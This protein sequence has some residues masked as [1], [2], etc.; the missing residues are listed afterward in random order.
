MLKV[1]NVG[2]M[3]ELLQ[4]SELTGRFYVPDLYLLG[5]HVAVVIP[6]GARNNSPV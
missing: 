1:R 4:A 6:G 5:S 2:C 3:L